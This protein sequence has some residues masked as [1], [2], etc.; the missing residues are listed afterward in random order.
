MNVDE[1]F[2]WADRHWVLARVVLAAAA[3][4]LGA[5]LVEVV[6]VDGVER[7][8]WGRLLP[9]GIVVYGMVGVGGGLVLGMMATTTGLMLAI[10]V[11]VVRWAMRIPG[12]MVRWAVRVGGRGVAGYALL[13][14][15]VLAMAVVLAA[16]GDFRVDGVTFWIDV[17]FNAVFVVLLGGAIGALAL[18]LVASWLRDLFFRRL[19]DPTDHWPTLRILLPIG[20]VLGANFLWHRWSPTD[21]A[22]DASVAG[23]EWV[24]VPVAFAVIHGYAILAVVLLRA[25]QMV[26]ARAGL[27]P[28][29]GREA[30]VWHRG[31]TVPTRP[32]EVHWSPEAVMGWRGWDVSGG[33]LLGHYRQPWKSSMFV[34]GCE[35]GHPRPEWRC[36]CGIYALKDPADVTG[37]VIGRVAMEGVVIE[38]E[39]GYRAERARIVELWVGASDTDLASWLEQNYPDVA[40]ET[41]RPVPGPA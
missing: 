7:G 34:A 36:N 10:V 9:L 2:R 18:V 20:Y 37:V 15:Y 39:Q 38:H 41:S 29:L 12:R 35:K 11:H 1:V 5:F 16:L 13:A 23:M 32:R 19:P 6:G 22:F 21:H 24:T 26:R 33:H 4:V 40:V 25:V 31:G 28:Q 30:L 27:L 17:F 8:Q 14:C 3:V